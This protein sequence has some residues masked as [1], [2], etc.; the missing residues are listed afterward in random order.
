MADDLENKPEKNKETKQ[1]EK[2]AK[3]SST[4]EPKVVTTSPS[5]AD[6][7]KKNTSHADNKPIRKTPQS[8]P[9]NKK[10]KP[11]K[12]S[13]EPIKKLDDAN[14]D[15]K[16]KLSVKI[17]SSKDIKKDTA[18][19]SQEIK[20][21]DSSSRNTDQSEFVEKLVSIN[22]VAKVVKGGRRFSFAALVVVGDGNGMV[23]HGKGKAKEVPEAIKKATDEAKANM[24]RVPLR[25]GRTLH[26][27]IKGRF[28]SGKVYLR[29]APSGTGVIAGGPMR[30]VFEALGI[31]D[32]V[33]KS[34]GS[35]NP[36]NMIRATFEAL[37][38]SSSP[39]IIAMRR[40]LKINDITKR[41]KFNEVSDNAKN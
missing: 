5:K 39:K 27:D 38:S 9:E 7:L 29:S 20:N 1:D 28:D 2:L 23:G 34:V 41:R 24:I 40:G 32:I 13:V 31:Q 37:K 3:T 35:S 15:K 26:H 16:S 12:K 19:N 25:H 21:D 10:V 36:H 22:R 33:A 6:E 11:T 4:N 30:A 17:D 8:D 18:G 14:N